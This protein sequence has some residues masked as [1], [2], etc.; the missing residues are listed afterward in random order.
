MLR[1]ITFASVKNSKFIFLNRP[2]VIHFVKCCFKYRAK[3]TVFPLN[4]IQDEKLQLKGE[5]I[6]E[7]YNAQALFLGKHWNKFF[8]SEKSVGNGIVLVSDRQ[9]HN[10]FLS[11]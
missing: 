5:A 7:T 11:K 2:L 6:S 10:M 9:L 8:I 3:D 4:K 1:K